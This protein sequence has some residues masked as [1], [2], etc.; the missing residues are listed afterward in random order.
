[1]K[2]SQFRGNIQPLGMHRMNGGQR[3]PVAVVGKI[4][5]E[6]QQKG[7]GSHQR[8]HGIGIIQERLIIIVITTGI[9]V[10]IG[11]DI[12]EF[13]QQDVNDTAQQ[14]GSATLKDGGTM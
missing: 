7:K 6:N 4:G 2:G 5:S 14:G 3:F 9:F 10:T 11:R 1:M 13:V 12:G 8:A